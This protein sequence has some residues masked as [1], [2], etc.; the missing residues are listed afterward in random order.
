M[1]ERGAITIRI[2]YPEPLAALLDM[3]ADAF[4]RDARLALAVKLYEL[5]RLTS[6]QAALLAGIP[7]AQFLLSLKDY[8]TASVLWDEAEL[9]AERAALEP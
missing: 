3:S 1:K 7:R 4:E 9:E 6:G 8:G 2:E 5:N